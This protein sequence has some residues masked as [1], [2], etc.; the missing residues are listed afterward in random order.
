[1]I[2]LSD[3]ST[4]ANVVTTLATM[5]K[6]DSMEAAHVNSTANGELSTEGLGNPD[7]VAKAFDTLAKAFNPSSNVASAQ[8]GWLGSSRVTQND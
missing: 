6:K 3:L 5:G 8:V 4:L 2:S 7:T 1:M